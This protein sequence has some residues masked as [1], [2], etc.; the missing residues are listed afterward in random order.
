MFFNASMSQI[1]RFKSL[2]ILLFFTILAGGTISACTGKKSASGTLNLPMGVDPKSLDPANVDD[3]YSAIATSLVYEGLLEY[4]Y[5]KRP[6]ELR[7]LL[8]EKMPSISADGLTYTFNIK[9]GVKFI[10]SPHFKGGKGREVKAQDFVYSFMRIADPKINSGGFWIFDGKI[11]GLNEWRE[12]NKAAEKVNYDTEI[13]GFKALDDHTLQ[14]QL[15]TKYP[16]L[17]YVLA[18][19]YSFVVAREVVEKLGKEFPNTPVG[20]GPYI[21]ERWM[22]GSKMIFNRNP[23]YHGGTYPTQGEASDAE[24]GL[25]ADAGKALPIMDRVELHIFKESQ[26]QW[27]NFLKGNLDYTGIPKDNF[28][29]VIDPA[30][31]GLKPDF[32]AKGITLTMAPSSDVTYI[33]FNMED[34]FIKKAGPKF[35]QAL[36]LAINEEEKIKMF[37]NGRGVVAHSP[38]PPGLA[39]YDENFKNPWKTFD[40]EKAKK[41][42]AEAGF[43]EGK[44]VPVIPFETSTGAEARQM[45][46]DLQ[47]SLGKLGIKLQINVNQ[48]AELLSK[49]DQKKAMMWGVAWGADY[50]DAENFLQLLYGPNKAPGP[51]GSNFDDAEYNKLFEQMRFMPDSPERRKIINRMKEIFVEQMPW[52]PGMHRRA[53]TLSQ[54]WLKNF[55]PEYMGNSEAKFLRV[56]E[57]LRARGVK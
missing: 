14:I 21:L 1:K 54:P 53:Y 52:I 30:T 41:I 9:K 55:K 15:N 10:D 46:E 4:E 8:A 12:A 56:D 43:P 13:A 51:N 28:D 29:S 5:L 11:K 48:F 2:S 36:S 22:R 40:L 42:L 24:K 20:T 49:I 38:V 16:Q 39:G 25:L 57:E 19:P 50:P 45:A 47:R 31:D 32:A 27:L 17:L 26:P 23:T 35:R 6:H 18:M 34:P 33:A 7:P 3:R 37:Y 44:G